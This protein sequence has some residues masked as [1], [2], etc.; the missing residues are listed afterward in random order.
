MDMMDNASALPTC[1][2]RQHQQ[3]TADRNWPE[4]RPH[5]FTM[6]QMNIVDVPRE[7]GI[8]ANRVLPIPALPHT[9][10]TFGNITR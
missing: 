3:Q 7:I 4:N 5:D 1:P 6:K 10:F 9:L 2:Q 8:I